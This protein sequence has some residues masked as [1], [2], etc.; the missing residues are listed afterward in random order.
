NNAQAL[1]VGTVATTRLGSQLDT[2]GVTAA[3]G[4]V[5]LSTT[6][7]DLTQSDTIAAAG[8]VVSLR[9]AAGAVTQNA[10]NTAN[11]GSPIIVAD[12]LAVGARNTSTLTNA[13]QVDTLAARL[14]GDTN[15]VFSFVS[16]SGIT[17]AAVTDGA[18]QTLTGLDVPGRAIL[19]ASNGGVTQS[20]LAKAGELAVRATGDIDLS[21]RNGSGAAV[22]AIEKVAARTTAGEIKLLNNST[23]E[24][25][26]V[27]GLNGLETLAS[28]K[29]VALATASGDLIVGQRVEVGSAAGNVGQVR[30]EATTGAIFQSPSGPVIA[31]SLLLRA[32]NSSLVD[33]A[34]QIGVLAAEITGAGQGLGFV[35]TGAYSVGS[36]S[37]VTGIGG[38]T[39]IAGFGGVKAP[40]SVS[41]KAETGN[42]TQTENVDVGGLFAHAVA[43]DVLLDR[44]SNSIALLAGR[45][46]ASSR[47][48]NVAAGGNL[49]VGTVAG[50]VGIVTDQGEVRL[51]A[52]SGALSQT[53]AGRIVADSLVARALNNSSLASP[54]NEIATLA[55]EVTASGQGFAFANKNGFTVG[56]V[57]GKAGVTTDGGNITLRSLSAQ[58]GEDI[59]LDQAVSAGGSSAGAITL[60]SVGG[61]V[62]A[63]TANGTVT[64]Q[65]LSVRAASGIDLTEANDVATLAASSTQGDIAFRNTADFAIGTVGDLSGLAAP[66]GRVLL[67]SG[68]GVEQVAGNINALAMRVLAADD[69]LLTSGANHVDTIA[70]AVT[71]GD[72]R[73]RDT[74]SLTIGSVDGTVGISTDGAVWVRAGADLTLAAPVVAQAAGKEALVLA[75]TRSFTNQAGANALSAP[76]GR[77]LVYDDNPLLADRFDGMAYDFRRL[78]TWYD[79]YQPGSV[80]ELGN[81]YI[82][83]AILLDPDQAVRQAGGSTVGAGPAGNT[84]TSRA[85]AG[86]ESAMNGEGAVAFLRWIDEPLADLPTGPA[87]LVGLAAS[88]LGKAQLPVEPLRVDVAVSERFSVVIGDLLAGGVAIG[89]TLADGKPL[90]T[91]LHL[92]GTKGVL[93]GILPADTAGVTVLRLTVR[94][95]SGEQGEILLQLSPHASKGVVA[96]AGE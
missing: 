18:G 20:A 39:L 55:A 80:A 29:D 57:D 27:D 14:T 93:A 2:V 74:A 64:A 40:G 71:H 61:D 36:V 60:Q 69:V 95:V 47:V 4:D 82:T 19:T 96:V 25:A 35:N 77:W 3:N 66:D 53:D 54:N 68:G 49:A 89:A 83:T 63:G 41:L 73:Y 58:A 87:P 92:D 16:D 12:E 30:L 10:A 67:E 32:R 86:D 33:E 51:S 23:I 31:D 21:L 38:D 42:I 79:G 26:T 48:F 52:A 91:W 94:M 9:A 84:T 78:R 6:A 81:G 76:N 65:G 88:G 45:L 75:A 28:G 50:Q 46:D 56:S 62:R 5:T 13:N 44:A 90:P 8:S 34:N 22:N 85:M 15:Q 24:I 72:F 70:A 11:N 43:G 59:V 17:I 7:G 1:T 37:A